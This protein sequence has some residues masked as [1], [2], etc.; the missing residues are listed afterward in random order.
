[1]AL[2]DLRQKEYRICSLGEDHKRVPNVVEELGIRK[3]LVT[4]ILAVAGEFSVH[5]V[6][7][8]T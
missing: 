3:F 8:I 4:R 5:T 1:M 7:T 2:L 6:D